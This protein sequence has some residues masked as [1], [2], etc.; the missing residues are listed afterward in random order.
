MDWQ[1]ITSTWGFNLAFLVG[2]LLAVYA[3]YLT[4]KSRP[5]S[6][7]AYDTTASTIVGE[8][9]EPF[10]RSL[11]ITF[12]GVDVPRATFANI[13]IWND[14]NQTIR[15][16][17]ITPKKPLRLTLPEGEKFLQYNLASMA[18]EAMD[19]SMSLSEDGSLTVSFEYIEPGQGFVCEILHTGESS[20]L[21]LIG[22]LISAKS[23]VKKSRVP[24]YTLNYWAW[25]L[26]LVGVAAGW[27][28]ADI[29]TAGYFEG[30]TSPTAWFAY[31]SIALLAVI[32]IGSVR[33]YLTL[34]KPHK[35]DFGKKAEASP[36]RTFTDWTVVSDTTP[37][38]P[39]H[40]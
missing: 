16:S 38:P 37:S 2:T 32:I 27:S 10:R 31:G 7:L 40:R 13:F 1:T 29:F 6:R 19:A 18:D 24:V 23:P 4:F 26:T 17:D 28:S 22:V 20:S 36:L 25:M 9:Q 5:V 3:L 11:K 33:A 14:G 21:N 12:E 39:E 30:M 8:Q 15:R 34:R 35:M